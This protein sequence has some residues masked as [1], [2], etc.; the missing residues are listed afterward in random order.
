M[1]L[2]NAHFLLHGFGF[3][4]L[5]A[6]RQTPVVICELSVTKEIAI[7]PNN[8]TRFGMLHVERERDAFKIVRHFLAK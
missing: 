6:V 5:P 4:N 2:F 1:V 3:F 8:S 7:S